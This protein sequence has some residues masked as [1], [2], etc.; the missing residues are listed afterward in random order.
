M[1]FIKRW[2]TRRGLLDKFVANAKTCC[3]GPPTVGYV[4]VLEIANNSGCEGIN[5]SF[6]WC[7]TEEGWAFWKKINDSFREDYKRF[8][9]ITE[10]KNADVCT[11][12]AD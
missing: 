2:L 3:F 1:T 4:D 7:R 5:F 10:Q 11:E 9:G 8:Y 6:E 12:M